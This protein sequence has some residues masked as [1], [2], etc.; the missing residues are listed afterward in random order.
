MQETVHLAA[1]IHIRMGDEH[2]GIPTGSVMHAAAYML[3]IQC[4]QLESRLC[5]EI[6]DEETQLE[7]EPVRAYE[8]ARHPRGQESADSR[9]W[10]EGHGMAASQ[11]QAV[12]HGLQEDHVQSVRPVQVIKDIL[13]QVVV[14][15]GSC[16]HEL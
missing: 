12:Q 16:E 14:R 3:Y 1:Q 13:E 8:G 7:E 10:Q 4:M 15:S 2:A 5:H 9:L 6:W 11:A